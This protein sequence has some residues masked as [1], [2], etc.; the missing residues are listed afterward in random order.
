MSKAAPK[1]MTNDEYNARQRPAA[2]RPYGDGPSEEE[3]AKEQAEYAVE[4]AE[5]KYEAKVKTY[6]VFTA[7]LAELDNDPEYVAAHDV[8]YAR[9]SALARPHHLELDP[10][11]YSSI[12]VDVKCWIRGREHGTKSG[13]RKLRSI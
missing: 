11:S 8:L 1:M 2:T 7:L 5:A 10:R 12:G 6:E 4:Q 3:R 9:L 13:V